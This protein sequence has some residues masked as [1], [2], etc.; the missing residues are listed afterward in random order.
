VAVV[1]VLKC[2]NNCLIMYL[3]HFVVAVVV[4]IST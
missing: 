3:F 4:A 2:S 1:V